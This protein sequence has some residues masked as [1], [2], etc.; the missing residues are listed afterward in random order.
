VHRFEYQGR[1]AA[2]V[3][4]T[5]LWNPL[6]EERRYGYDALGRLTSDQRPD[7]GT[8]T[9]AR[10]ETPAGTTVTLTTGAGLTS[11][12][13]VQALD[14]GVTRRTLTEPTGAVTESLV[15]S[16]GTQRI[17]YPDG[18]VVDVVEG[19]DPRWG[20]QLPLLRSLTMRPPAGAAVTRTL[21]R[22]VTLGQPSNPFSLLTQ[23]DTVTV[24]GST[25]TMA[26]N[27]ATRTF[28]VTTPSG[29][30]ETTTVDALRRVTGRQ[31]PGITPVA[32]G[33]DGSAG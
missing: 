33:R 11:T 13:A 16:D 1:D 8:T 29:R 5:R 17:A 21:T 22:S 26:W 4:H 31:V 10:T 14:D 6:G 27:A 24:A 28:T 23:T 9:L 25:A 18:T 20:M 32:Y 2:G 19:P 3:Y 7:G 15:R 30:R 12:F